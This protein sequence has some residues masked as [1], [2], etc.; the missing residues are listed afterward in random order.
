[1]YSLIRTDAFK[2]LKGLKY[3]Q[4]IKYRIAFFDSYSEKSL[5]FIEKHK[6]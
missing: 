4:N 3:F 6:C 5:R 2:C 1:M